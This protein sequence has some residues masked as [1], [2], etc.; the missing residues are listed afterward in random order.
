M[1]NTITGPSGFEYTLREP[2][3]LTYKHRKQVLKRLGMNADLNGNVNIDVGAVMGGLEEATLIVA[4]ASWN[5]TAL[6]EETGVRDSE[7][8]QIPIY[9]E[10]NLDQIPAEDAGVLAKATEPL[11]KVLMPEFGPDPDEKSPTPPSA[12]SARR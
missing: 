9:V 12:D 3:G 6:D 8:L 11:R 5:L 1:T 10:E 2:G 4:I 7:V